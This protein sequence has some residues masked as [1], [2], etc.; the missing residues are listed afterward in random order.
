MKCPQCGHA[1]QQ[2]IRL[3]DKFRTLTIALAKRLL[4][5][6]SDHLTGRDFWREIDKLEGPPA[7][8]MTPR[9]FLQV[10][11]AYTHDPAITGRGGRHHWVLKR[12][13]LT[14][15]AGGNFAVFGAFTYDPK[16]GK[17]SMT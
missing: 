16:T 13:V 7:D 9:R 10:I 8:Y 14:S 17:A 6:E 2:P 1:F 3:N 12:E 11:G 4:L 15:I 5:R